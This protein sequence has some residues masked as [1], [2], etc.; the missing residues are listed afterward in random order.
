[1]KELVGFI[2]FV[3]EGI[4]GKLAYT[5]ARGERGS[6]QEPREK[7][8]PVR[9]TKNMTYTFEALLALCGFVEDV[10]TGMWSP[11]SVDA[12]T[13][14]LGPEAT[15]LGV[16]CLRRMWFFSR[17][18][19]DQHFDRAGIPRIMQI[20]PLDCCDRTV[21]ERARAVLGDEATDDEGRLFPV[22]LLQNTF[23]DKLPCSSPL[24]PRVR[25]Y[26]EVLKPTVRVHI[27][28]LGLC[29]RTGMVARFR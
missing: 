3:T 16:N 15:P 4:R 8:N 9:P 26:A 12:V 18:A 11:T 27:G 25:A 14:L 6:Q 10:G 5:R 29:S 17:L 23:E 24:D 21:Y 22:W 1:M 20:E 19:L 2:K 13:L 7:I 28:I